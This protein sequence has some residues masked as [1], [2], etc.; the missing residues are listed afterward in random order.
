MARNMLCFFD[1]V[2]FSLSLEVRSV[3]PSRRG[4]SWSLLPRLFAGDGR[5]V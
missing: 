1:A 4:A 2:E 5:F 3:A